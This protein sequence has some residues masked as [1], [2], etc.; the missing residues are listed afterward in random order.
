LQDIVLNIQGDEPLFPLQPIFN[1]VHATLKKTL[2]KESARIERKIDSNLTS[3]APC[4]SQ[5]MGTLVVQNSQFESF[6]S[7]SCVKVVLN[8]NKEAIYFSRSPVPWPRQLFGASGTDWL[9]KIPS[10]T[11]TKFEFI[12]HIG[13]YS[14]TKESLQMFVN[15]LQTS[16]LQSSALETTEGLE[17]LRAVEA[18]WRLFVEFSDVASV[19]IDTPEDL[20][21]IE[22]LHSF[23]K[24]NF[25]LTGQ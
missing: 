11:N 9:Q 10:Q 20:A 22:K 18:G 2:L 19:G 7:S 8:E 14:F 12:Q 15:G 13:V 4:D 25:T 1:L 6:V 21:N 17:Q 16:A 23:E 5:I 3:A 24:F